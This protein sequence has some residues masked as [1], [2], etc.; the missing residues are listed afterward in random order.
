MKN[1]GFSA[2]TR[3]L[4]KTHRLF[5]IEVLEGPAPLSSE[6]SLKIVFRSVGNTWLCNIKMVT[7]N[8]SA[9]NPTN[10]CD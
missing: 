1:S 9:T 8:R 5:L 2:C 10:S 7:E 4:I 6:M 3:E